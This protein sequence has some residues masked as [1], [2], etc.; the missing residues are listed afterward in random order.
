MSL[1]ATGGGSLAFQQT[2]AAGAELSVT[3][4]SMPAAGSLFFTITYFIA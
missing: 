4:S 2:S 1:A 3:A